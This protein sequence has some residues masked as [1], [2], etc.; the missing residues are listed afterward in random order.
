MSRQHVDAAFKELEEAI[1]HLRG[2]PYFGVY[3]DAVRKLQREH[4]LDNCQDEVVRDHAAM[5]FNSGVVYTTERL[6]DI[7]GCNVD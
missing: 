3:L 5:V 2:N 7:A 6:L 4:M 1:G